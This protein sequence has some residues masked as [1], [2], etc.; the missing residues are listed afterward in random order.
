MRHGSSWSHLYGAEG[1]N[2]QEFHLQKGEHITG[3]LD[4][5][6]HFLSYLVVHTNL[7]PFIRFGCPR[8]PFL[9][10]PLMT[11]RRSSLESMDSI[12]FRALPASALTGII[13][14]VEANST[15][16]EELGSQGWAV[17]CLAKAVWLVVGTSHQGPECSPESEST[18]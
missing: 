2:P 4:S 11:A 8:G 13:L 3:V 6:R 14:Q 1:L 7:Q 16:T 18:N 15:S 10:P 5:F 9:S 17:G 12:Q